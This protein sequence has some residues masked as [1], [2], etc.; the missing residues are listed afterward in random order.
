MQEAPAAHKAFAGVLAIDDVVDR[1]EIG[2]AVALGALRRGVLPGA[3]LRVLHAF[4]RRRMRGQ[5]ILRAG[6]ERGLAGLH[7]RIALHRGEEARRAI[8]IEMGAG[9]NA[10]ADAVGL[11][12]LR[13]REA[14]HR[15]FGFRQR[16]RRQIGVVA[17]V[18]D[19]TGHH[20]SL[21]RLVFPDRGVFCEDMRHLVAQH[22][23]QFG[24][25]AG[26]RHQAARHIE[27]AGRQREGVDRA[28]I[29]D[30]HPVGLLGTVGGRDQPVDGLADQGRE[31]RIVIGAAIGGE[32]ALMF[33]LAG[34]R[35]R[36]GAARL[37]RGSRRRRGLEFSQI[38]TG[39]ERER[40]AQQRRRGQKA[41][42]R[43]SFA[44]FCTMRQ[45][46][47]WTHDPTETRRSHPFFA[48]DPN[49]NRCPVF[50]SS[51]ISR[52]APQSAPPEA[53]RSVVLPATRQ[54]RGHESVDFRAT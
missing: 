42:A 51:A 39:S 18:G 17:H 46:S 13:A 44:P 16:Q 25:V 11:E 9:R 14:R 35:L 52:P 21:P 2:L 28:G 3:G 1:G 37:R 40:G 29:E 47:H 36:D 45:I 53:V 30:G 43:A 50:G 12:F 31:F 20:R 19:D 15:Q 6:I 33:A 5:E 27:L 10:D 48:P 22:R 41:A 8:G 7:R 23:G 49:E 34:R 38:S 24:G 4:G 32:N 26:E 54:R